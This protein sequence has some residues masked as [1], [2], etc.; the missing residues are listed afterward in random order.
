MI[1]I[2]YS[3]VLPF[4]NLMCSHIIIGVYRAG[5][6]TEQENYDKAVDD[7][8]EHLDKL[9]EHLSKHRYLTGNSITHAD[10]KLFVTLVR[11]DIAYYTVLK[12]S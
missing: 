3:Y 5:F 7:L 6:S 12:V 1:T 8:F 11:F 10:V 4:N 2:S 9:E